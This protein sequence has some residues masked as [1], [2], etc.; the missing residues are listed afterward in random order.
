MI[1]VLCVVVAALLAGISPAL[2]QAKKKIILAHAQ[3]QL[4]PPHALASSLPVQLK[5]WQEEGLDVEVITTQGSAAAIQLLISGEADAMWG[6]PTNVIVAIQRGAKLKSIYS[7]MRG[8]IFGVGVNGGGITAIK[9]QTVGVSS[10]ASASTNYVKALMKEAGMNPD[11][12]VSIVEVGV[13]ARA[14]SAI[15]SKQ[16][17]ALS[18]WD[19]QFAMLE[20]RGIKFERVLQDMRSDTAVS[21]SVIV[22]ADDIAKRRDMLV[23]L[24][25]GI[26]KAQVVMLADPTIAVRAHWKAYPESAPPS[27]INDKALKTA[28]A[29]IEVRRT[30]H[31]RDAFGTGRYGD[32]PKS[33]MEKFQQYLV[34]TEQIG[35][36]MDVDDYFTNELIADI[37]AFD[38]GEVVRKAKEVFK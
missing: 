18:L 35:R 4:S 19:E 10:F 22:R 11:R 34:A 3:Q 30:K 16:V 28:A 20:T 31:G 2:A 27:G 5:Y 1:R 32:I 25:R 14:A 17:Q 33:A 21:A 15:A 6:N 7:A 26:A 29:V 24:S 8:D 38:E 23:G 36:V 37:N 12:D 9:G 13:G